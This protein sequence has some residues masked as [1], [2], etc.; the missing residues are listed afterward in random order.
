MFKIIL[1]AIASLFVFSCT[2]HVNE[3]PKNY[4]IVWHCVPVWGIDSSISIT[5]FTRHDTT[6]YR[7]SV[8]VDQSPVINDPL[9]APPLKELPCITFAPDTTYY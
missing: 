6:Y 3:Q 9:N 5:P 8:N 2:K 4:R 7:Y 1:L